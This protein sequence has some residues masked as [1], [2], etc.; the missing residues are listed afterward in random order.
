MVLP[1][2]LTGCVLAPRETRDERAKLDVAGEP[3]R[4]ERRDLAE[5]PTPATW[6]DV[7]Q[8]ALL[9]NGDLE[10]SYFEWRA[11]MARIPQ[12]AAWPNSMLAPS[13]SYLFS[14][15][16]MKSWDRTTLGLQF[17]P[18]RNLELPVKTSKRGRMALAEARA[19]AANFRETKF[20]LQRQVL[21]AYIDLALMEGRIR[22]QHENVDLLKILADTAADRVRAGA[23]Q[24]DLLRAQTQYRLAENEQVNMVSQHHAMMAMLN[25]MMDRDPQSP[26]PLPSGL[27]APRL[28]PA[29]DAK[30]IAAATDANPQLE[31]LRREVEG[32]GDGLELAKL[33][34]LPDINPSFFATGSISQSIGAMFMLPTTI[35]QI[36]GAIDEARANLRASQAM[37]RQARSDRA[38]SFVAALVALRNAERQTKTFEDLILPRAEQTLSSSR[39]A[40]AAATG[41]FIELIDAQRTLLDVRLLIAEAKAE[42]EK[43]LAE[44]EEL[45]GVDVETL[46]SSPATQ[47]ATAMTTSTTK[48]VP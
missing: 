3:Y 28:V 31:R 42:R 37:L 29:D 15:G 39:Q 45:S 17:D 21:Q 12:Q 38:G 19:A 4:R 27:P 18:S 24:Q 20:R 2:V 7:L 6:R 16:N 13:F 1:F 41:S 5:L 23:N 46:G 25:A 34:Y 48:A 36:R 11:A 35:P 26:I 30:L 22:I 44:M 33:A 8:R 14:G 32:R 47:P 10:A 9:A 40:Y 43:R